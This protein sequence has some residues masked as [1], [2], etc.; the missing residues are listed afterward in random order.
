MASQTHQPIGLE[1]ALEHRESRHAA[2]CIIYSVHKEPAPDGG[3]E[4]QFFALM[5]VRSDGLIGFPGGHI[6]EDEEI[7]RP[8][9]VGGLN[10]ELVEE[11]NLPFQHHVPTPDSDQDFDGNYVCSHH[12]VSADLICHFF[13]VEV[14]PHEFQRIE[15][16]TSTARDFP[17]ESLGVFRVPVFWHEDVNGHKDYRNEGNQTF[18]SKLV[19]YPFCGNACDQLITSLLHLNII[20]QDCVHLFLGPEKTSSEA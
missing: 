2:H 6:D 9:I 13:Q 19:K 10:R 8:G 17:S 3:M 16:L 12:N 20:D 5:Q 14:Q 15:I 11:M 7:S 1:D 18:W 4:C